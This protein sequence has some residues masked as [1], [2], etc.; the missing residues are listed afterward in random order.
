MRSSNV[1]SDEMDNAAI[2]IKWMKAGEFLDDV[3]KNSIL[4]PEV[5]P[6]VENGA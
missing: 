5:N 2:Y 4:T 1:Q 3:R 6:R